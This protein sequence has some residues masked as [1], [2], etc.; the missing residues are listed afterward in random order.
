MGIKTDRAIFPAKDRGGEWGI[1]LVG[2]HS[3]TSKRG[4]GCG[5]QGRSLPRA[6]RHRITVLGAQIVNLGPLVR[7]LVP[8]Q[9]FPSSPVSFATAHAQTWCEQTM[10]TPVPCFDGFLLRARSLSLRIFSPLPP[11]LSPPPP[12][13]PTPLRTAQIQ[14]QEV[15]VLMACHEQ[16]PYAKFFGACNDLKLALDQCFVVSRSVNEQSG[17]ERVLFL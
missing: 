3:D 16:N 6:R 8:R 4:V 17:L 13:P 2:A 14:H 7:P 11:T 15:K 10:K 1:V 9:T 5:E 12:P